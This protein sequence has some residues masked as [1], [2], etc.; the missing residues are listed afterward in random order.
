MRFGYQTD[1]MSEVGVNSVML[2]AA[3]P[4]ELKAFEAAGSYTDASYSD[5]TRELVLNTVV[6]NLAEVGQITIT[7]SAAGKHVISYNGVSMVGNTATLSEV[8]IDSGDMS[9][10]EAN[11][12]S[13]CTH[14]KVLG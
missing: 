8:R 4:T 13:T 12:P 3:T 7:D 10:V 6:G 5:V 2:A 14:T 1:T 11:T 9:V